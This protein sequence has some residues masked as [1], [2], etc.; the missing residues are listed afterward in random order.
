[1][2]VI[3]RDEQHGLRRE[4][5]RLRIRLLAL[6]VFVTTGDP[7][8]A[9][10]RQSAPGIAA[11]LSAKRTP[12]MCFV[13][14]Q[15]P[16]GTAAEKQG[17]LSG[18]MS[19]ADWGA[20]ARLVLVE[21]GKVFKVLTSDFASA[22]DP[23]VSFDA[24][25]IVFAGQKQADD[26]WAIYEMNADGSGVRQVTSAIDDLRQP[27]YLPTVHTIIADPTKGTEPRPQI[28]YVRLFDA[29]LNE[30]GAGRARAIY[31]VRIDGASPRRLSYNLSSDMNPTVLN[32]GR[33]VYASWRRATF[34]RGV[35]GRIVLLGIN[36][37]G[38]DPAI[39][40]GDEGLRLKLMPCV[41]RDRL[42][43]FVEAESVGWDGAGSLGCVSLRRNLHSR[44]R[45]T[46]EG[47]GLF[48]SPSALSDGQIVA[49][50]RPPNGSG[51]HG[52]VRVH[53]VSGKVTSL[54]DDA[55]FHDIQARAIAPR[56]APDGRSSGLKDPDEEAHA[57][58]SGDASRKVAIPDVTMYGLNVYLNDLGHDLAEGV[59]RR[60]RIIEGMPLTSTSGP[61]AHGPEPL[62]PRRL[63][64]EAP[65][66]PDGSFYIQIPAE[67]PVQFQILD[68][69]GLALRTSGWIW[70]HYNGRQGCVGCHEDPERT[71]PSRF[72]DA[73][74]KPGVRLILPPERRRAVDYRHDIAPIVKARCAGCHGEDK[75]VRLDGGLSTTG[76]S[77]RFSRA[78]E[79]LLAE[80]D[81]APGEVVGRY[82]H[83]HQAR[84]SP[85]IWHI[86]GRN[87]ARPW[88]GSATRAKAKPMP[89]SAGAALSEDE[90]GLFIEWIDMGALWDASA[91]STSMTIGGA[92]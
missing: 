86:L 60:L 37:D 13:V 78:Y 77:G 65:I 9:L 64:G 1:M 66:E 4:A 90:R 10:N 73:L 54:F 69:D 49:A 25:S 58:E 12:S 32:D 68:Q 71:P 34:S 26:R 14:T 43:A 88:D 3:H 67:T 61:A 40:A 63:L 44:R 27:V 70:G 80:L 20:G 21:A 56:P 42:V 72:A 22:A 47:D 91:G 19:P 52:I 8:I 62:A 76:A 50:R 84:T 7:G 2:N 15:L 17:P 36:P 51:D 18:G 87:T 39:F 38:T 89:M 31:S 23:D 24:K 55:A 82:V 53:P 11:A 29:S 85:L 33:I 6:A 79:S 81:R 41:T 45:I 35:S 46:F 74:R 30:A 83:P 59:I 48:L 16:I 57:A 92:R 5:P 28:G 75:M